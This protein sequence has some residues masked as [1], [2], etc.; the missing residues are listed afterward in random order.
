M[1]NE[2]EERVAKFYSEKGWEVVDG[3]TKDAILYEDFR[4]NA[5]DYVIKG[6]VSQGVLSKD[7][8][9]YLIPNKLYG[10]VQLLGVVEAGFPSAAE[11]V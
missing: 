3:L 1:K 6:L 4:E 7:H 2:A 9:G 11:E 5:I 8:Q 10:E